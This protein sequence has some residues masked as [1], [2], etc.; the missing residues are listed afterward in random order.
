MGFEGE[1]LYVTC[2]ILSHPK[3]GKEKVLCKNYFSVN[4]FIS[5]LPILVGISIFKKKLVFFSGVY[6]DT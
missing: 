2:F 1:L 3:E 5:A 6:K 4:F